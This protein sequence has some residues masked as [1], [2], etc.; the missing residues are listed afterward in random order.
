MKKNT[1]SQQN[2]AVF[3]A[4]TDSENIFFK[5]YTEKDKNYFDKTVNI[6]TGTY[7]LVLIR[8]SQ[9]Y[10]CFHIWKKKVNYLRASFGN[11]FQNMDQGTHTCNPSFLFLYM[12]LRSYMDLACKDLEEHRTECFWYTICNIM[13]TSNFNIKLTRNCCCR[14]RPI[15]FLLALG[16]C[17]TIVPIKRNI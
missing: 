12:C 13:K 9:K 17:M 11:A 16:R 2:L 14:I 4:G 3:L 1:N 6:R 8:H 15:F 5:Y 10:F 7:L